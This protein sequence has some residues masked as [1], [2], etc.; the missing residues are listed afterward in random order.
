LNFVRRPVVRVVDYRGVIQIYLAQG[1]MSEDSVPLIQRDC[2]ISNIYRP[3]VGIN[4]SPSVRMNRAVIDPCR[5]SP[6]PDAHSFSG[7]ISDRTIRQPKP[8][9]RTYTRL[10]HIARIGNF[11]ESEDRLRA[12]RNGESSSRKVQD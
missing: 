4:S 7:I 6:G 2:T 12:I 8:A 5:L 9:I 10:T 3:S 11:T 1:L